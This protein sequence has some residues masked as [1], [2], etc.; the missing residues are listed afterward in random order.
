VSQTAIALLFA[1]ASTFALVLLALGIRDA[2]AARELD[3]STALVL[4]AGALIVLPEFLVA[5]TGTLRRR[6]DVFGDIVATYPAWH[7]AVVDLTLLL[8]AGLAVFLLVPRA[9]AERAP[10]HVAG[11][12]AILLWAVANLASGLQGGSL[13]SPRAGV[14]LLCLMAAAVLPRGRGACLGAGIFGVLLAAASGLLAV[15]RYEVAFRVPCEAA[16]GGLGFTGVLPNENLLG[17]VLTATIPFAYLG[18]RGRVRLLLAFYLAGMAVATGSRT[19]ALGSVLVVV[20]LLVVRP[21]IDE[22]RTSLA[23]TA[24]AWCTLIA[25]TAASIY[26]VQHDWPSSALTTRPAL[27][28]VAWDYIERSPWFGYGPTAW[29][30]L[31]ESSEIPLAA[32]RSTHNQ[33]TDVLF[34]AGIVGA[35][36]LV[37]MA[38]AAIVSAGR[39]RN[40]VLLVL[41][42]IS[43]IGATE[44]AWSIG[45][46]DLLSF[47]LVALILTGATTTVE[48]AAPVQWGTPHRRLARPPHPRESTP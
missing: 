15:F 16:C 40:S 20:M 34:V 22:R 27:W 13:V 32:Q 3:A 6:P 33:W 28:S 48:S 19:A 31:Y 18:F 24:T 47:S 12:L 44:G 45:T 1:G 8:L 14:L 5:L 36:L 9:A 46:V 21:S 11:L 10:V 37:S 29:A 35:V 25:T 42:T 17:A 41:A 23:R 38:V 26:I 2:R 39:A 43:L 7:G 4:G 30:T